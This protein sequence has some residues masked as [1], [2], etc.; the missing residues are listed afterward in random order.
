V[1]FAD[2]GDNALIFELHFWISLRDG[3]NRTEVES[4]LR[5][6]IDDLFRSAGIVMAY[7]QRDIHL[8][9]MR[10]VDVRMIGGEREKT[11][12]RAA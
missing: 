11:V 7:P 3:T 5:F 9:V 2:F 1:V 6:E 12:S 8:N 4:E 10:P